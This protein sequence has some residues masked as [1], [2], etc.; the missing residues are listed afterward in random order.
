MNGDF[1]VSQSGLANQQLLEL[2][3]AILNCQADS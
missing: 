1:A 3:E 2:L